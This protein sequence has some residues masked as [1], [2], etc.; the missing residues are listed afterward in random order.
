[1]KTNDLELMSHVDITEKLLKEKESQTTPELFKKIC[2]QLNLDNSYYENEISNYY[3]KLVTDKRFIFI[4]TYWELREKQPVIE[5]VE[6]HLEDDDDFIEIEEEEVFE[7]ENEEED[8]DD[9]VEEDLKNLTIVT[10]N[11]L[12]EE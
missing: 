9:S 4:D 12:D 2:Q 3:T 6:D 8:D 1:M 5:S 10:E 11:Y 7:M